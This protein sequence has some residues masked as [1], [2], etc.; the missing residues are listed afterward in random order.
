M[1]TVL[2]IAVLLCR[3][4]PMWHGRDVDWIACLILQALELS[5]SHVA[6]SKLVGWGSGRV[7]DRDRVRFLVG[8]DLLTSYPPAGSGAHPVGRVALRLSSPL[9]A[10]TRCLVIAWSA[11]RTTDSPRT[12][13]DPLRG[14]LLDVLDLHATT[15]TGEIALSALKHS[16]RGFR[17]DRNAA[18]ELRNTDLEQQNRTLYGQACVA[19][20]WNNWFQEQQEAGFLLGQQTPQQTPRGVPLLESESWPIYP[21]EI[22]V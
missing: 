12:T 11:G 14:H 19:E 21:R 17:A 16:S 18:L 2:L 3:S 4:V 10:E 8:S 7:E 22:T 6:N 13:V 15:W 9:L 1:S 20:E 5:A